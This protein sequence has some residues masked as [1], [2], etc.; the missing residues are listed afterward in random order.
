M[1]DSLNW[2][3]GNK[4]KVSPEQNGQ[5][6]SDSATWRSWNKDTVLQGPSPEEKKMSFN[7]RLRR[8]EDMLLG[9]VKALHQ[10][11]GFIVPDEPLPPGYEISDVYFATQYPR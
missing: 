8:N 11:F 6:W 7:W 5:K 2:R 1:A 4:T 10:N 3:S 9:K